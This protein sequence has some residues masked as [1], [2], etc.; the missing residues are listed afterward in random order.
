MCQLAFGSDKFSSDL[1][2]FIA[3]ALLLK[4]QFGGIKAVFTLKVSLSH[5][6]VLLSSGERVDLSVNN[7]LVSFIQSQNQSRSV[8]IKSLLLLS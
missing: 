1:T 2:C 4:S 3:L 7:C 6:P 8:R 5:A